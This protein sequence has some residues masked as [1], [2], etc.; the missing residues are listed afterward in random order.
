MACFE[1]GC[2]VTAS[3]EFQA[4]QL[5][6]P[7]LTAMNPVTWAILPIQGV[8]SP[9]SYQLPELGFEI[10]SEDLN[11]PG[12]WGAL[13]LDYSPGKQQQNVVFFTKGPSY[14]PGHLDPSGPGKRSETVPSTLLMNG[15]LAGCHSATLLVTHQFNG[16]SVQSAVPGDLGTLT[17]WLDLE[18]LQHPV[19]PELASCLTSG[20]VATPDGG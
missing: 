12:L 13:V 6:K 9:P 1:S 15:T 18:D 20:I 10:V 8:G 11:T 4:P 16:P 7:Y 2:A 3:P 14:E 5:T 17:W 19:A